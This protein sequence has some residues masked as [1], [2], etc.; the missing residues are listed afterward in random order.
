MLCVIK[1]FGCFSFVLYFFS[2]YLFLSKDRFFNNN[3]KLAK[4]LLAGDSPRW[5]NAS[6]IGLP[7]MISGIQLYFPL[8]YCLLFFVL[9]IFLYFLR[10]F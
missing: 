8:V 9:K 2:L 4:N 7:E 5:T 3:N 6:N 1:L 10:L